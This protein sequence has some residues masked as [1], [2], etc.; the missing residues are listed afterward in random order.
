MEREVFIKV[1]NISK[2]FGGFQALKDINFQVNKQEIL[3]IVGDN[4]AGKSTLINI[5]SGNLQQDIGEIEIDGNII[6][7]LNIK[8]ALDLGITTLYQ[9]LGLVNTKDSIYNIFLGK[10][11]TK[12]I[13][14]N[15]G[16]MLKIAKKLIYDL[17]LNIPNIYQEVGKLSGGQ[18]Q[19]LAIARAIYRESDIVILDEPTAAMGPSERK[20]IINLIRGLKEKGKGVIVISHDL[21]TAY[22]IADRILVLKNGEQKG[23]IKKSDLSYEELNTLIKGQNLK[24]MEESENHASNI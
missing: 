5:L 24:D 18:R 12:G 23:Y 14:L 21:P 19:G 10:E 13:F 1:N 15:R 6:K 7:N 17:N 16:E 2:K 4:G 22:N 20:K 11:L 3:V 8:K 9:E